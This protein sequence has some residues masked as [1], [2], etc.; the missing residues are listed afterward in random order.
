MNDLL[1]FVEVFRSAKTRTHQ[2]ITPACLQ[3]MGWEKF[4][5]DEISLR[6][7]MFRKDGEN[8]WSPPAVI[9]NTGYG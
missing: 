4:D 3:I 9:D 1:M 2:K 6:A 5:D 8:K 7:G